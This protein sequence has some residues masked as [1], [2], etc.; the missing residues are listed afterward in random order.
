MFIPVVKTKYV[1]QAQSAY[2]FILLTH[3]NENSYSRMKIVME[4]VC[5]PTRPERCIIEY[6]DNH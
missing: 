3:L 6:L 1:S 5:L 4:T 2:Y